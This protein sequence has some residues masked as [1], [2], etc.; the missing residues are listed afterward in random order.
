MKQLNKMINSKY[1]YILDDGAKVFIVYI[2]KGNITIYR[3]PKK[4]DN[5]NESYIFMH[6]WIQY[7]KL[8]K[9]MLYSQKVLHFN[10]PKKIYIGK[11]FK[12]S[13]IFDGNSILLHLSGNKYVY[14]GASIVQFNIQ[15]EDIIEKF[16]SPIGNNIPYPF[17]I[18]KENIYIMNDFTYVN[19][20]YLPKELTDI[21]MTNIIEL[22]YF[23]DKKRGI[24][25]FYKYAKSCKPKTL[26]KRLYNF[27]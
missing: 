4:I 11:S 26:V 19:R 15:K 10:K 14:I 7:L 21:D 9:N 25:P 22:F 8:P 27:F 17:I 24:E 1:Y 12:D 5:N 3:I 13:E 6:D 2:I 20:K 16:W 23:G 18:G